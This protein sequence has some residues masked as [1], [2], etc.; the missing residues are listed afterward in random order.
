SSRE[1]QLHGLAY[2]LGVVAS[3]MAIAALML[4]LRTAGEAIGWGFQLQSPWFIGVLIY[5]LFGLALSLSGL[6]ELGGDW[7]GAGQRLTEH[8]GASGSFFTGVLAVLVASPCTAPFMGTALGLAVLL[9]A[10]QALAVFLALGLGLALPLTLVGLI[11]ALARALPRP[12]AWME[13][14]RQIMAFPLYLTVVWLLWVLARQTG[15]D[16]VA[17][18]LLGMV[19]L[20]F[21]LWLAGR[22]GGRG[23]LEQ[24]RHLTVAVALIAA[25]GAVAAANRFSTAADDPEDT[26]WESWSPERLAEINADP[27]RAAFVNMTADWCVT[28]LVNEGVALNTAT[29]RNGFHDAD[30]V[31]LKGDWTRRDPAIT[32]YLEQFGR[33]GVPL[34]VY[35]PADGGSPTVLP[36]V[37]TPAIILDAVT[38][39]GA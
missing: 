5:V 39:D 7:S 33:N 6:F 14:F 1:L 18:V 4:S 36:Q 21:A 10:W 31:Y 3:F 23:L 9:P 17:A 11:P 25:L 29:V 35:Y 26:W 24:L 22:G 38:N 16:G 37:L 20:A 15:A 34:Y 2:T 13:T 27:A 8:G 12:G 32:R 19:V 30:V 28:C